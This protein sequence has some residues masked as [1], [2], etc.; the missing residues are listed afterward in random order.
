MLRSLKIHPIANRQ[1][2]A[3]LSLKTVARYVSHY[4][5]AETRLIE[6][7]AGWLPFIPPTELKIELAYQLYED[8]CHVDT[9]RSRLP[10]LGDFTHVVQPANDAFVTFCNEL[11]NTEDLLEQ[12]VG[13]FWVLRP[14][15]RD[16]YRRYLLALDSVADA[17]T[18]R[19]LQKAEHDHCEFT[20]WSEHVIQQLITNDETRQRAY[21]WQVHLRGL[22]AQAG[23]ITGDEPLLPFDGIVARNADVG[24]RFRMDAPRR[25]ERFVV[26]PYER[27]EGRAAT[28]VWDADSFLKYMF[29]M[30][31]GEIEATE[32]CA[33]TL[34]D[35]PDAPWEFRFVLARQLWDEAR[36]AELS[37]QRFFELG[38]TLDMLPV[39]S[40]FPLYFGPVHNTDLAH[41]LA[42]LNQVVEG[43][44]TDDFAMMLDICRRLG[45][46][47]SLRL[48]E[49]LIADE[50]LHLKIGADWIPR[51]TAHNP[52]HRAEVIAYRQ[53][54]ETELYESLAKVAEETV[55]RFHPSGVNHAVSD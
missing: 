21:A 18:V 32:A 16:T 17:P 47:R 34:F 1:I 2:G 9:M 55:I 39:R 28:D 42:H 27:H 12:L 31:E 52:A 53:R 20:R 11:T 29:M 13:V 22:L 24:K 6:A 23:G 40:G 7:I 33:R 36:H 38:G 25:D 49:Q 5:Y 37:L 43:W 48:F 3:T 35:Y 26:L 46:E 45:D 10:E 44:V 41:R 50:W 30:V 4:A 15:L 54:V 51:F 14:S 19:L 8:A